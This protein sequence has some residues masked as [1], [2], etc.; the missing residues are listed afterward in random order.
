MEVVSLSNEK[1][2]FRFVTVPQF[3]K[4]IVSFR[5]I[6]LAKCSKSHKSWRLMYFVSVTGVGTN[7][8]PLE[9]TLT[10]CR[11]VVCLKNSS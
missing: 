3:T 4:S 11:L 2:N 9:T 6:R 1:V 10:G 7:L 5:R 8:S